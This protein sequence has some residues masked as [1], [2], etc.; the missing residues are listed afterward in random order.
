[1]QPGVYVILCFHFCCV[2]GL[3]CATAHPQELASAR[4]HGTSLAFDMVLMGFFEKSETQFSAPLDFRCRGGLFSKVLKRPSGHPPRLLMLFSKRQMPA[5]NDT[6]QAGHGPC[7][8]LTTLPHAYLIVTAFRG[9]QASSWFTNAL[10]VL[11]ML[12]P[13]FVMVL[14]GEPKKYGSA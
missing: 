3:L 10:A 12:N 4:P 1:M 13:C 11:R 8:A 6:L 14:R 7:P 5:L 9:A 2:K